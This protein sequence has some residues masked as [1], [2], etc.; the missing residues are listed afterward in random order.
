MRFTSRSFIRLT[1]AAFFALS[2]PASLFAGGPL[3]LCTPGRPYVWPNGGIN[4]PFN[5]DQGN[6]GPL[7]NAQ[8]VAAVS[9]AFKQWGDVPTAT[10]TYMNAGALPLDVDITN[11]LDFLAAPSPDG[12]SA[13]VFDDTGEI[14]DLLFGPDSGVL[15]FA[16]PE[17]GDPETC[18]IQEGLAFLNGPTFDN[19]T[20]ALDI[21]VHEFGHYQNLGHTVVN[22]QV[23]AFADHSGASPN[24]TFPVPPFPF[25]VETMYPFYFG[26]LAGTSSPHKDDISA[27]STLYPAAGF[28]S[29]TGSISGVILGSNRRT[30]LTG[31]NVIAR[32]L[33]NPFDDAVSAI[34][35]D[36]AITYEQSS[37]LTGAY[38]LRG[39]TAGAQY[40]L[41]VDQILAGGFSTPPR[42]LPGPEEFYNGANESDDSNIDNR[43]MFTPITAIAGSPARGINIIFNGFRPG[44]ILPV[45]DDGAVELFLPFRFDL[46]GQSFETVWVNGNGSVTFGA[47]SADFSE[48]KREFLEGPARAAGI[49]DDLNPGGGGTVTFDETAHTFTVSWTNV[50]EFPV[51]GS[52]TFSVKLH[53]LFDRVDLIYGA[54][55]V[56][57]GLAGVSCGGKVTSGFENQQDL[58]QSGWIVELLSDPA[59][60]EQFSTARPFD[61][62]NRTLR[63]TGTLN[64]NDKWAGSND[65][66]AKA[67]R[68]PVP[69][70][71]ASV[72]QFTELE[73]AGDVDFFKFRAKAGQIVVVEILTGQ[74]DTLLGL[75]D[76]SGNLLAL[77][78]QDG[79]A[80]LSRL[81]VQ[82]NVEIELV[83]G[84]TT[85]PDF[86][87]AGATDT[88]RYVLSVQA[89][90]G[91][92]IP[93][94]D[95]GSFDLPLGFSFPFQGAEW[96]NVFVNGNG[97]LTFG[98]PSADFSE[99]IGEFLAG[100][101]RIAPLWDDLSPQA[102]V[103]VATHEPGAVTIHY[104][105]VPEFF[106]DRA[107]N[108][109]VRLDAGGEI[110][111][112]YSGILAPDSL[113]GITQGAGVANPGAT[114]LSRT[115]V[116]SKAGTTYEL[117][118]AIGPPF[119]M[120]FRKLFFR[121]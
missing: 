110:T 65:T 34:S 104:L 75:F 85:F 37:S 63:F 41:Y 6:L 8:A 49:W 53:R 44:E 17:W 90:N 3:A 96:T 45:G 38:T 87:F 60:F 11:F 116:L 93:L 70:N 52:N 112:S 74:L 4:I 57:D 114:D 10:T 113:V 9:D 80:D 14:F 89:V 12:F 120:P 24:N 23:F 106:S 33:A 47:A 76:T 7:T 50:P 59:G 69:F 115:V 94:G 48:S 51:N 101:P 36:F 103:V 81:A 28:A 119:D 46:C 39:L 102:G 62:A 42:T 25:R 97:N 56:V 15:G 92:L 1:A 2:A 121:R 118:P 22:G 67:K 32:N 73:K 86:E 83:V 20:V 19:L 68:I 107:N 64:Y 66:I 27:L 84:V 26:P 98:A 78:D 30:R 55:T 100:P 111:L 18:E 117:F 95:D 40:A 99:S 91:Q 108:F 13:I 72:L 16:G 105:S 79:A 35:S 58:S 61:L 71:S 43:S 77:D 5:P 21:L 88:G 31:V 54:T 109:S 29:S 82:V